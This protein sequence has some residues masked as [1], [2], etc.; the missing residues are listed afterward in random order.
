[1]GWI[2]IVQNDNT[3]I[4][5]LPLSLEMAENLKQGLLDTYA[6]QGFYYDSNLKERI[7]VEDVVITIIEVP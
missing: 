5:R 3:R 7:K 1:M 6:S 4:N 2:V